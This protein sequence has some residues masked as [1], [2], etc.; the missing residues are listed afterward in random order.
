MKI[1]SFNTYSATTMPN[2]FTRRKL[3]LDK[4]TQWNNE[5]VDIVCLQE[6]N[7]HKIGFFS[8]LFSRIFNNRCFDFLSVGEGLCCPVFICDNEQHIKDH[9]EDANLDY[10][11]VYSS[12][13]PRYFMNN[14]LMILSKTELN[15]DSCVNLNSDFIHSPGFLSVSNKEYQITNC[16]LIPVLENTTCI[17]SFVNSVNCICRHNIT[18]IQ[19]TNI[20]TMCDAL[21]RSKKILLVGDMNIAK[22]EDNSNYKYLIERSKL[23]DSSGAEECHTIHYNCIQE[24][25]IDYILVSDEIFGSKSKFEV[26]NDCTHLSDHHPIMLTYEE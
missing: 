19:Q 9:I 16:H 11:Y 4:I 6:Q 1:I 2:R 15:K 5:D 18:G 14:G 13:K 10:K 8:K 12:P 21:D 17:Y 23:H 20:D 25:Q 22:N 24:K 3:L 26:L 7:S